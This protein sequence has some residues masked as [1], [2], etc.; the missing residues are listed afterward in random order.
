M[1]NKKDEQKIKEH[2]EQ[3]EYDRRAK[4]IDKPTDQ[5]TRSDRMAQ[6]FLDLFQLD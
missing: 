5:Q 2:K 4:D 1:K 3:L 6:T